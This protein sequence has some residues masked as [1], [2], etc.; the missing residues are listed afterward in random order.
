ML[1]KFVGVCGRGGDIG[2][3]VGV[4]VVTLLYIMLHFSDCDGGVIFRISTNNC[5]IW[6]NSYE[7]PMQFDLSQTSSKF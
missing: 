2:V 3:G 1:I 4:G 7:I 5:S 6:P